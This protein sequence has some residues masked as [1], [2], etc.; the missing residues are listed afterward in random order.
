MAI[1]PRAHEW[2]AVA[3]AIEEATPKGLEAA[4]KAATKTAY[5]A[6][7][8]RPG[9]G[10]KL[11]QGLWVVATE[12]LNLYGP[13]GTENEAHAALAGG[14]VPSY[15]DDEGIVQLRKDGLVPTLGGKAVVLPLIGPLAMADR[16]DR[17]DRKARL[18]TEHRCATCEHKLAKHGTSAG[19][20]ACSI[21]GCSC[22]KPKKLTL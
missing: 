9:E 21:P 10:E 12:G 6:L 1:T 8:S 16:L 19:T 3:E 15:I 17:Q 20:E 14:E 22:K 4:A 7:Q 5:A 11:A 13:F 2:Q 18:F